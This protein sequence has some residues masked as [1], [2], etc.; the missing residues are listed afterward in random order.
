MRM[1]LIIVVILMSLL[2]SGG[3]SSQ[4]PEKKSR[5]NQKL[6]IR[7][8]EQDVIL[9]ITSIEWGHP[10]RWSFTSRYVHGFEKERKRRTWQNNIALLLFGG[11]ELRIC[12]S[13]LLNAGAGYYL[14]ITDS[15]DNEE[16]SWR[17]HFGVGI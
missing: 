13:W 15:N 5:P 10:D 9:P 11:V 6:V 14:P 4:E 8:S 12:I 3:A 7:L 1:C 16:A 17:F 2:C